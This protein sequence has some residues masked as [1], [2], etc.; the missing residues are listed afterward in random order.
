MTAPRSG[1]RGLLKHF[2]RDRRG[3]SAIEF[4]IIAPVMIL[5][6]FGI[7]E[8]SG[9]MMSER[10]ASRVG[11]TIG[12]LTAQC[13]RINDAD[14][15][16]IFGA[17]ATIM[18]PFPTAGLKMRITSITRANGAN[19]VDWSEVSNYTKAAAPSDV[20]LPTGMLT[21]DG[22]S[23]I[24]AEALYNYNSP[25]NYVIKNGLNFNEKFFLKPRKASAAIKRT[26]SGAGSS[27]AD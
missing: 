5:M 7:G 11:S 24:V 8:L 21:N 13:I 16:D 17:A 15:T 25:I 19:K 23:V 3:V 22:E 27:C 4:A 10:R 6:Y 14:V 26:S 18:Q 2:W 1:H 12:D 9:A 20:G